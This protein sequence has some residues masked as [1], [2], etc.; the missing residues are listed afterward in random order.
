MAAQLE[1]IENSSFTDDGVPNDIDSFFTEDELKMLFFMTV[2]QERQNILRFV[3]SRNKDGFTTLEISAILDMMIGSV[4]H[5]LDGLN[6]EF[7]PV[8]LTAYPLEGDQYV[9]PTGDFKAIDEGMMINDNFL[10]EEWE[11]FIM[12]MSEQQE[13][14]NETPIH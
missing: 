2:W 11:S 10:S 7:P 9:C 13:I 3:D 6:D 14:D 4:F 5:I 8:D 12:F 1:T